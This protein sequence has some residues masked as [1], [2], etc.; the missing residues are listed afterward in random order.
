MAKTKSED[1]IDKGEANAK[2]SQFHGTK[3]K[4]GIQII[5]KVIQIQTSLILPVLSLFGPSHASHSYCRV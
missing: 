4:S 2:V 1:R 5:S 3:I